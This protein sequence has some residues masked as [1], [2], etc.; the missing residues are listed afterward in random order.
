MR[1]KTLIIAPAQVTS[2]AGG[3]DR[4]RQCRECS[5][6]EKK[7]TGREKGERGG[8]GEARRAVL[9]SNPKISP[10][11]GSR[12]NGRQAPGSALAFMPAGFPGPSGAPAMLKNIG[13]RFIGWEHRFCRGRGRRLPSPEIRRWFAFAGGFPI[14]SLPGL[15]YFFRLYGII[16]YYSTKVGL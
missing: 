1:L 11:F 3:F 5:N 6:R 7:K 15:F 13:C 14:I 4:I 2:F 9:F 10:S 8:Q 16:N 12:G